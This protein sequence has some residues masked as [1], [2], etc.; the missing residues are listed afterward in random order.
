MLEHIDALISQARSLNTLN[1]ITIALGNTITPAEAVELSEQLFVPGVH[2]VPQLAE[3]ARLT[4]EEVRTA[5]RAWIEGLI[6]GMRAVGKP[7]PELFARRD[8]RK[9]VTLYTDG[10]DRSRKSLLITLAGSNFRLMMSTPEFLQNL[11]AETT[12][13]LVIRDGTRSDYTAGL[14]GLADSIATLGDG[15]R[16]L[17]PVHDYDRVVGVGIS[18]GG[19]PIILLAVQ[20]RFDAALACGAGS[21]FDKK[22]HETRVDPG[23]ILKRAAAEG[24]N[25]HLVAAYGAQSPTDR[26]S[27]VDLAGCLRVKPVEVAIAGVEVKHNIL[28]R[29]SLRGELPAF[30][31]KHLGI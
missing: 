30:F 18:A 14:E 11:R 7:D 29:L 17:F 27:A 28:H 22:W 26:T 25:K 1:R 21:P 2:D 6:D 31:S 23:T 8:I 3:G 12:D 19:L 4:D 13:V 9:S 16:K 5:G 10:G 15:I 24:F 20:M